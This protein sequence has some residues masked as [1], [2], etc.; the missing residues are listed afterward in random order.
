MVVWWQ[1][2]ADGTGRVLCDLQINRLSVGLS[3]FWRTGRGSSVLSFCLSCFARAHTHTHTHTCAR[4]RTH[5]HTHT[6]THTQA[7]ARAHTHTHTHT[8]ARK[9][10]LSPHHPPPNPTRHLIPYTGMLVGDFKYPIVDWATK[11][12]DRVSD[13]NES[14]LSKT[15]KENFLVRLVKIPTHYY[16]GLLAPKGDSSYLAFWP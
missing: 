10:S 4:T 6:Y 13:N 5:T 11:I 16:G 1:R 3:Q 2:T 12:H 9:H 15:V 8:G 7:R 14:N